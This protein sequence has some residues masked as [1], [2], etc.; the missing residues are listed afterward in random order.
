MK[1]WKSI[2]PVVIKILQTKSQLS[3]KKKKKCINAFI[4]LW[5]EKIDCY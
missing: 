4:Y 2:V 1:T 3:K 5:Q